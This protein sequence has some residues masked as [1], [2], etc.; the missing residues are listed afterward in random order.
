MELLKPI[1]GAVALIGIHFTKPYLVLLLDKNTTYERL[2]QAFPILYEDLNNAKLED[3]MQANHKVVDFV[4]NKKFER[5]LP[6][7]CLCESVGKSRDIAF[8]PGMKIPGKSL[9]IPGKIHIMKVKGKGR[10]RV[11]NWRKIPVF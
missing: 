4:N 5:S 1:F 2:I 9:G 10:K 3:M 8:F 6:K 7:E 11:K